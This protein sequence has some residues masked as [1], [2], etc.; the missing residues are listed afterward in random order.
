MIRY[1]GVLAGN[2]KAR[3]EVVP[4]QEPAVGEQ[5]SLFGEGKSASESRHSWAWLLARAFAVDILTCPDCQG[6]MRL[7]TVAKTPEQAAKVLGGGRFGRR[8]RAPPATGQL[9]LDLSA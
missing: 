5:L 9:E 4:K 3:S 7:V 6:A 8:S 2:A 1:H